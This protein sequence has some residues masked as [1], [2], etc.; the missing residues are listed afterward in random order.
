[1]SLDRL[2]VD[3]LFAQN[4]NVTKGDWHLRRFAQDFSFARM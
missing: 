3:S 2:A 1:M 4:E